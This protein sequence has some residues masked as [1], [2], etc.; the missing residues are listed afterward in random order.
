MGQLGLRLYK[1]LEKVN[2][3]AIRRL[4]LFLRVGAVLTS[5]VHMQNY[6]LLQVLPKKQQNVQELKIKKLKWPLMV[7]CAA[8]ARTI[9]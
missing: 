1:P 5:N 4:H 3:A 2:Q 9:F 7:H 6:R 8:K